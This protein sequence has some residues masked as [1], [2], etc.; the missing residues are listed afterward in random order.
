MTPLR[1]AALSL[2]VEP[3]PAGVD[4]HVIGRE[5][6]LRRPK[7]FYVR[8][9]LIPIHLRATAVISGGYQCAPINSINL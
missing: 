6:T 2:A 7:L 8:I 9:V 3:V 4:A 5:L 1:L